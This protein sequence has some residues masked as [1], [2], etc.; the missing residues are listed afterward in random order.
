MMIRDP[1][2]PM[3]NFPHIHMRSSHSGYD[4][5]SLSESSLTEAYYTD[6]FSDTIQ[7]KKFR[8]QG[9]NENLRRQSWN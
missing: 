8:K 9:V 3:F 7:P 5:K 2:M 4:S 1:Q 6:Y